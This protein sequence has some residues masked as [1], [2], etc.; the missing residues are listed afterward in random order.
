MDSDPLVQMYEIGT[1]VFPK[2]GTV[3]I[4]YLD[5]VLSFSLRLCKDS[6]SD[7]SKYEFTMLDGEPEP[8]SE[9]VETCSA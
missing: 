4:W 3:P 6:S 5:L 9:S 2:M 8:E 7:L 1:E